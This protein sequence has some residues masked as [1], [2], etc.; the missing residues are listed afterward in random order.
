MVLIRLYPQNVS[1]LSREIL[2]LISQGKYLEATDKAK[3]LENEIMAYMLTRNLDT[4]ELSELFYSFYY[5][6]TH[7]S[8]NMY[9]K[10]Y[11]RE[12]FGK[13][14][15]YISTP[16]GGADLTLEE[17]SNMLIETVEREILSGNATTNIR[18]ILQEIKELRPYY[19]Q[20]GDTKYNYFTTLLRDISNFEGSL[21]KFKT[22]T[23]TQQE[24]KE[25]ADYVSKILSSIQQVLMPPVRINIKPQHLVKMVEG[26]IPIKEISKATGHSEDDL[27]MLLAQA[28]AEMEQAKQ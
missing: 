3:D 2:T 20:K 17:L 14:T 25:M 16:L 8:A 12:I 7:M 23:L 9:K 27:R 6:S 19:Q 5:Y 28:R 13:I 26:G 1:E 15:A 24:R 18:A 11:L 10:E 22:K 4:K 21:I